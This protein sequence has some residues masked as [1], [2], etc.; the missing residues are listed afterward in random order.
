MSFIT[1]RRYYLDR[2][3]LKTNFFGKVLDLGG[4]KDNKRGKFRPPLSQV[5]SW[6]YLN[7]DETTNPDY[8]CS[9]ENVPVDNESFDVVLMAEVLEHLENPS[10]VL[11]EAHRILRRDGKLV[12]TMPFMYALHADPYDFQRWT[13]VKIK[14]ELEKAGFVDVKIETMGSVFSVI[15]DFIYFSINTIS[16]NRN[17]LKNKLARKIIMP[18]LSRLFL[19]LDEKY[20]YKSN[21]ITT[22]Y[23]I[24][25][26][27]GNID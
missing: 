4:K 20:M 27:K 14:I 23:Y 25:A 19:L 5:E 13:N 15:Y 12:A 1:F 9:A 8:C 7:I 22:G 3:L 18:V 16:K 24:E 26:K 2:V 10:S 6:E 17:A 21:S 11:K